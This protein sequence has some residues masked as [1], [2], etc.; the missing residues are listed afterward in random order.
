MNERKSLFDRI[1]PYIF[2]AGI[3]LGA[4]KYSAYTWE[5]NKEEYKMRGLVSEVRKI[6]DY[7]QDGNADISERA[8]VYKSLG[9]ES[10]NVSL[11]NLTKLQLETYLEMQK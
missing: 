6:A 9:I 4:I 8:A 5:K 10:D 2:G 7:N 1:S 11:E 3:V